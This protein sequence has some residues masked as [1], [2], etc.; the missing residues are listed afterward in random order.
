MGP[1]GGRLAI[2]GLW[3]QGVVAAACMASRGFD[4]IAADG[5]AERVRRLAEGHAPIFEPG[6]D[7]LLQEGLSAGRLRFTSDVGAAVRGRRDVWLMFDTAVDEND[8]SDLGEVFAAVEEAAA[9]IE[10]ETV[11][12]VTAQVPV[13]TCDR[14]KNLVGERSG[15][16]RFG[17]AYSPENLRLGQAIERFLNPA[18]PVVGADEEWVFE[19]LDRYLGQLSDRWER[20]DLRTAE[21]IKHAL[22]A[23]LAT[24]V[25]FGNEIG[26][27]C[28]VVGADAR[29]VAE[30][31]RL[32]PR[33]GSRAMIL[34]GLGFSGGTLARDMQTLRGLG[35][36]RQTETFMFD[37]IWKANQRQLLLPVERLVQVLGDLS[38]KRIGV[39]GL[40]Y[41]PGTSTL[42]R[43][44]ALLI[45][46]RLAEAGAVVSAHDPRADRGEVQAL[47]DFLFHDD[48]YAALEGCEAVVL[49]TGWPEYR[50]LDFT[51]ILAGMKGDFFLDCNNML[52]GGR[53]RALGFRYAGIGTGEW[54][55]LIS[56][57]RRE[58]GEV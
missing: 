24:S 44:A 51:K 46:A 55:R 10:P 26:N 39:L 43:S 21:M 35:D 45:I 38:G 37:G 17:I 2:I 3:H 54:A 7:E 8:R 4:V 33:V 1:T 48:P 29:R 47:T 56:A 42:R 32:E 15:G 12:L 27:L 36:E 58:A 6:L 50:E 34:P 18:L 5:D 23:F 13:G 49:V 19:R 30:V 20:T 41:K 9:H 28:D 14:L 40:T 31:L 57:E 53:M 11:M 22:N 25:T 16:K 52:D